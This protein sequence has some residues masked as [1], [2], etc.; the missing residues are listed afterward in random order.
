MTVAYNS[1]HHHQCY[2]WFEPKDNNTSN[3]EGSS[4]M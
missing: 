2:E 3:C 4:F 1:H